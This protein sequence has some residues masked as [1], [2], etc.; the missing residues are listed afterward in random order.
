MTKT[1]DLRFKYL[2]IY[3]GMVPGAAIRNIKCWDTSQFRL[4]TDSKLEQTL[5][6]INGEDPFLGAKIL[7]FQDKKSQ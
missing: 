4:L 2:T 3:Y 1:D 6:R 7:I 5:R